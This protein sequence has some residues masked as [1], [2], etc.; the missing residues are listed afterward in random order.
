M[1]LFSFLNKN[2]QE[3]TE[4]SGYYSKSDDDS[5]AARARSKRASSA[6]EPASRRG[7]DAR[8]A[9]DPV[10]PE[11]KRARRR[12]VGAVALALGVAVGLPMVLDS[13]PKPLAGD[14]DIRIPSK[15]KVAPQAQ[16]R[17]V[18]AA[19][20]LDKREEIVDVPPMVTLPKEKPVPRDE[21]RTEV[22]PVAKPALKPVV[23]PE[24]KPVVKPE[25]KVAA[26]SELKPDVKPEKPKPEPKPEP[27]VA[28][29]KH[30]E[31]AP[32]KHVE[33][34]LEKPVDKPVE[35]P[36]VVKAAPKVE[37]K[38]KPAVKPPVQDAQRAMSILEGK[39]SEKAADEN[40]RFVV[41]VAALATQEKVNELQAKLSGAG[42]HSF[43]HKV[44][45]QSGDRI[46]VQ[47]GPFS[48]DEAEKVRAKLSK[49]GLSGIMVPG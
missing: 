38:E 18:A 28:E 41:Q 37:E 34:V 3:S 42:I 36:V 43:T 33:K 35:K 46:R 4:D 45:T 6:G 12:L 7:K 14:I 11:K 23:R 19:D 16:P 8:A 31:K 49:M 9:A 27:K 30:V 25:P 2:K 1:G 10:L 39:A 22:K 24:P 21:V 32:E 13:E 5:V 29:V 17:A 26:R 20:A 48:K 47:V 40:Q 15:D 44:P